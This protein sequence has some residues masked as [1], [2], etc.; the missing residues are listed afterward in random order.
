MRWENLTE[1]PAD[2]GRVRDAAL[3]GADAVVSR[4]FD[5]PEFAGVTFHEVLCKTALNHV[6]GASAMPFDWTV[7]PY[8]GCSHACVYCLDPSTLI[9]M[10]DGRSKPLRDVMVGDR[11]VGTT[12]EGSYRRYTEATVSAKWPTRKRAYRIL[13]ADGTELIASADHRF[14]TERGWKYV[15]PAPAGSRPACR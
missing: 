1:E 11:V 13:L 15:T 12:R 10:A 5:T 7:N 6:P 3:F 2:H 14:L 9:Q 8:R 4:T